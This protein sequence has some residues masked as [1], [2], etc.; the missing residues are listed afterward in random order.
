MRID[1][2]AELA[3]LES[4]KAQDLKLMR[5]CQGLKA[6]DKLYDL[7][8]DMEPKG[9]Q[10]AKQIIR[11]HTTSQALKADLVEHRPR[12]QGHVVNNMSGEIGPPSQS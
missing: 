1:E 6:E 5:Y 10:Q 11:K 3:D 8:T 7:L 2:M 12:G 4:I 9:W